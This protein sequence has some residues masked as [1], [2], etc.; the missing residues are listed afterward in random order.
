MNGIGL[1]EKIIDYISHILEARSVELVDIELKKRKGSR[2]VTIF[3]DKTGG[4]SIQ[5]CAELSELLGEIFDVEDFFPY[6]YVLEVSSP[7]L[8]RLL[9]KKS[10][11]QRNL[12]KKVDLFLDGNGK[13][14]LQGIIKN[15]S[16][17]G[18]Q[19]A[20]RSGIENIPFSKIKKARNQVDLSNVD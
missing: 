10:D 17:S 5:E 13:R 11:F 6:S 20:I 18:I 2:F 12:G 3:V 1:K 4:I 14:R 7:G 9:T 16:E 8:D 19:L 15:V